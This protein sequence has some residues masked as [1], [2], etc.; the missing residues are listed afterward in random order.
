MKMMSATLV[1]LTTTLCAA[2][3]EDSYRSTMSGNVTIEVR[4]KDGRNAQAASKSADTLT[5]HFVQPPKPTEPDEDDIAQR[6][7]RCGE[8]WNKKLDAYEKG[9]PKLQRYLAYYKKW[10]AYPA[11]RPPRSA[12]PLLTRTTYRTCMYACLQDRL[13]GCPGGWAPET[14]ETKSA[15]TGIDE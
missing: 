9:L 2:A 4:A 5:I 15:E 10:E 7:K 1:L 3:A 6:L 13:A 14:E 12:E 11:Q 8:K